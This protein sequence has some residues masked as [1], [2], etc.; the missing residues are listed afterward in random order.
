M[1]NRSKWSDLRK[2]LTEPSDRTAA[3]LG[4]DGRYLASRFTQAS[5]CFSD[6]QEHRTEWTDVIGMEMDI[7]S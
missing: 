4:Q 1:A 5:A 7:D 6:L 2:P 3:E